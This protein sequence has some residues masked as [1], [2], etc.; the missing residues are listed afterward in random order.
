MRAFSSN[1]FRILFWKI[2]VCLFVFQEFFV[3]F[4]VVVV[5]VVFN[6]L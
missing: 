5:V 6:S 1:Y 3:G 4:V 2:T